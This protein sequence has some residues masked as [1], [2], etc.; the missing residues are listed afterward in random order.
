MWR[1]I[2]TRVEPV[3]CCL[4]YLPELIATL[5]R[6]VYSR[7]L[8]K[9][10]LHECKEMTIE[11]VLTDA[12]HNEWGDSTTWTKSFCE[13]WNFISRSTR[14]MAKRE[15]ISSIYSLARDIGDGIFKTI[16]KFCKKIKTQQIKTMETQQPGLIMMTI[17]FGMTC[18]A[19]HSTAS[20]IS[21]APQNLIKA[22]LLQ[23]YVFCLTFRSTAQFCPNYPC[24]SS[25]KNCKKKC[26]SSTCQSF[27]FCD[28][29][30][31]HYTGQ[32]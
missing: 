19:T 29:N 5:L 11:D 3:F 13:C 24:T 12:K 25:E 31:K 28:L 8:R 22:I 21:M 14:N 30:N 23:G 2:I 10:T 32:H 16:Y 4:K 20:I 18:Y 1:I 9:K 6:L 26:F 17:G 15:D 7:Y 27:D